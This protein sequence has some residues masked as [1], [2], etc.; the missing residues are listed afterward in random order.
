MNR[1]FQA[2]LQPKP[3]SRQL[4][5]I[6]VHCDVYVFEWLLGYAEGRN[7]AADLPH[8]QLLPVLIASDFLQVCKWVQ[9][10]W[11]GASERMQ[12][13]LHVVHSKQLARCAPIM[14]NMHLHVHATGGGCTGLE[15]MD[16]RGAGMP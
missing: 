12:H 8:E 4:L 16:G 13:A 15:C 1:Y 6:S 11:E 9:T 14:G 5:E 2:A 7:P 10:V 3:G